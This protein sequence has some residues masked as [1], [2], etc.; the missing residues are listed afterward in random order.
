MDLADFKSPDCLINSWT[1]GLHTVTKYSIIAVA[2]DR[3]SRSRIYIMYSCRQLVFVGGWWTAVRGR[4]SC[5]CLVET[6]FCF[7]VVIV[8]SRDRRHRIR[9]HN[10]LLLCVAVVTKHRT[11]D[12]RIRDQAELRAAVSSTSGTT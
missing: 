6:A 5:C 4:R 2:M 3:N 9:L 8:R 1:V 10:T 7:D 11:E 12:T